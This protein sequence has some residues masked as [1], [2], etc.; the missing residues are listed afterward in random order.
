MANRDKPRKLG[1][2]KFSLFQGSDAA[3]GG[4]KAWHT[5]YADAFR[6]RQRV[7]DV[8]CGPG[9]FLDLLRERAV[10]ALGI[11]IDP[12][13]AEAARARGHEALT[14][15]HR[16]LAEFRASFDGVHLSHIIE[17][18]WGDDVVALLESA[19][20][21]LRPLGIVIVRTPNWANA[22]VRHGGFWLDHTHKR[23]YPRELVAKMLEDIGFD[24]VQSG[25]EQSGWEDTYVVGRKPE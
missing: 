11:D 18:L 23:P 24:V 8:G 16:A 12:E 3:E 4:L 17:H 21:A 5:P 22:T 13:M 19:H 9:F 14:G 7:V 1:E 20:E 15:E 6:G 10:P 25:Y 2:Q